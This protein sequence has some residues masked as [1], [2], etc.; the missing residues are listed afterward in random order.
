MMPPTANIHATALRLGTA[1]R[2]FGAP[3]SAGILLIGGSG[4]G[5]S[6]LALRLVERG[7]RLVADDRTE[8]FMVRER[9]W[10]RA[11]KPI[12]GLL[13]IRGVG[14][15]ELP[16]VAK[17]RIALV[18][19]LNEKTSERIPERKTWLPPSGL[20]A[21]RRVPQLA[22]QAFEA[23]APAKI[24]AATASFARSLFREDV[25]RQ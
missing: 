17:V 24:A 9:L 2:P 3:A 14:I 1:G 23:S 20:G 11:P 13:E 21:A 7:A 5:K 19:T 15:V 10:A 4:S 12:A 22:L 18:V 16:H 8:L 25:K 6:D